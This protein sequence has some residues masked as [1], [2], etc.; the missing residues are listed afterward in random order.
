MSTRTDPLTLWRQIDQAGGVRAYVDAQLR[1]RGF[2]VERRDAD[3]MSD[4]EKDQYKKALKQEAAERKT[5]A[6]EAWGA[7]RAAHIVHL[8]DGIYWSDDAK[9][10][11]WDTPNSEERAAENELPPLDSP[12]QLAEALGVTVSQLRGPRRSTTA[13]SPS[14][15][16]TAPSAP[17]GRRSR[18]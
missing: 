4:R 6:R 1:E 9:P 14:R 8:G 17:S 18:G 11:K 10:D 5:L 2:L 7:Y 3:A 12:A 15:S 13:G 16:A